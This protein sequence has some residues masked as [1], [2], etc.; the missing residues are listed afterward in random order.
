MD[1]FKLRELYAEFIEYNG[2]VRIPDETRAEDQQ[3]LRAITGIM[4]DADVIALTRVGLVTYKDYQM[5][6]VSLLTEYNYPKVYLFGF[7]RELRSRKGACDVVTVIKIVLFRQIRYFDRVAAMSGDLFE[8]CSAGRPGLAP[9]AVRKRVQDLTIGWEF[10]NSQEGSTVL[11]FVTPEIAEAIK[12]HI[13]FDVSEISHRL[14]ITT[15][16]ALLHGLARMATGHYFAQVN[17]NTPV[18]RLRK[19]QILHF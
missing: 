3:A 12:S 17:E 2:V 10:L 1:S 9:N 15:A 6:A 16:V 11:P 13:T 4:R 18:S 14:V 19:L 8:L 7:T 5:A